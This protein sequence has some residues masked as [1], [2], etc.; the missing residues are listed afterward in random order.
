MQILFKKIFHL[1]GVKE[2]RIFFL[3]LS[4]CCLFVLLP[5]RLLNLVGLPFYPRICLSSLFGLLIFFSSTKVIPFI[6][7]TKCFQVFFFWNLFMDEQLKSLRAF[8]RIPVFLLLIGLPIY[9]FV[10]SGEITFICAFSLFYWSFYKSLKVNFVSATNPWCFI[11]ARIEGPKREF[12][13]WLDIVENMN[14]VS[15]LLFKTPVVNCL[16][17]YFCKTEFLFLL[18]KII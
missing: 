15:L 7:N 5:L 6:L 13:T 12:F 2:E 18:D 17:F 14:L 3:R 9:L 11:S 16:G 1:F 4:V 10:S 8:V